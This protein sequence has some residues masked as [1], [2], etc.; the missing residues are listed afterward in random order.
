MG[1]RQPIPNAFLLI[2]LI[3]VLIISPSPFIKCHKIFDDGGNEILSISSF[4]ADQRPIMQG[5]PINSCVRPDNFCNSTDM[6]CCSGSSCRCNLW[7]YDCRCR[8]VDPSSTY[9]DVK[10]VTD[11]LYTDSV[12]NTM[13]S[14]KR[15]SDIEVYGRSCISRGGACDHRPSACC[16]SSSCRCNFWGSNCRCQRV[17]LFQKLG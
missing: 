17:G 1:Q 9:D 4:V 14:E 12:R 13:A 2:T 3:V 7:G 10:G 16:Y 11:A 6:G 8:R 5:E 15:S